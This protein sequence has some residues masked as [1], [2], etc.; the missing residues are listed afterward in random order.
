MQALKTEIDE[1]HQRLTSVCAI[2]LLLSGISAY[3][4]LQNEANINA[5]EESRSTLERELEE[6][7]ATLAAKDKD[8]SNLRNE[9]KKIN[10]VVQ[11]LLTSDNS[12]ALAEQQDAITKKIAQLDKKLAAPAPA[13]KVR[14]SHLI[15]DVLAFANCV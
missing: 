12:T 2:F 14:L 11:A 15:H 3:L 7:K 10:A 8:L 1:L 9:Y 5:A 13:P 4:S 6:A